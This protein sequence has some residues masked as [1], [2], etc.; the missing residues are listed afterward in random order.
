MGI[1]D[2]LS[3]AD[4]TE[5]QLYPE[6][7]LYLCELE[8]LTT[9]T[10]KKHGAETLLVKYT[11]IEAIESQ[12]GRLL[13]A[14]NGAVLKVSPSNRTGDLVGKPIPLKGDLRLAR[15]EMRNVFD[16]LE[17]C[18]PQAARLSENGV[19]LEDAAKAYTAEDQPLKG[20]QFI[21]RVT[22]NDQKYIK[23]GNRPY[24]HFTMSAVDPENQPNL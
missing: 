15:K 6:E 19:D 22:V 20:V 13:K 17:E 7:G 3:K 12:P 5:E 10:S 4:K 11:V 8:E 21:A 2:G 24:P 1:F 23:S 16:T 9:F 18:L 14:D